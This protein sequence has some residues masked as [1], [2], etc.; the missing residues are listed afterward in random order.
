[1]RVGIIQSNYIP[2][3]GY[4]DF[5]DDCDLFIYHDDLQYTKGDWRNRNLIK[6]PQGLVYLTVPVRYHD[7]EQR[8]CDTEI[9]YSQKWI[10]KHRNLIRTHYAKATHF[11][12]CSEPF[13]DLLT[14]QW[15]T[16]S[17]LNRAVNAWIMAELEITT[18]VRMSSEF[19]PQGSKTDR[20]VGILRQTGADVYLSGPAAKDYLEPEKLT[21]AGIVLE[22]KSYE[23]PE[24]PQFDPPF[25]PNVTVL[26]LLF[27][28]GPEARQYLKSVSP[29]Q[30]A[31]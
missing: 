17:E 30:R 22:Y 10:D 23:Y 21:A 28:C 4:F 13:F 6:T 24:Y 5:I 31:T 14:K 26:D 27:H 1:M 12:R 19:S 7:V 29:N 16:I 11:Q 15:R 9:D 2:W 3:R 8:I 20:L 25:M 18:P